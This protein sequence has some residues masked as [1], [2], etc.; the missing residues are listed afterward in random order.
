MRQRASSWMDHGTI[1]L[2]PLRHLWTWSL[3]LMRTL[4]LPPLLQGTSSLKR[5]MRSADQAAPFIGASQAA[6]F[7]GGPGPQERLLP[8]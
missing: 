6:P 2:H 7:M 8:E 5:D 4:W 1:S 3:P